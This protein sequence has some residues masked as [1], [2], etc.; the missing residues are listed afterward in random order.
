MAISP[1]MSMPDIVQNFGASVSAPIGH[2]QHFQKI[3][4]EILP[5]PGSME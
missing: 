4:R 3:P 5:L 1:S 2:W